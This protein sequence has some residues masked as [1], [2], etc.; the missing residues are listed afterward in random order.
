MKRLHYQLVVIFHLSVIIIPSSPAQIKH[1]MHVIGMFSSCLN[2]TNNSRTTFNLEAETLEKIYFEHFTTNMISELNLT[3]Y[4]DL[5]TQIEIEQLP[6]PV[7]YHSFDVCQNL[8]LLLR[9]IEIITLDLKYAVVKE[10]TGRIETNVL[11]VFTYLPNRMISLLQAVMGGVPFFNIDFEEREDGSLYSADTELY[12]NYLVKIANYL[13]WND[14]FL[15]SIKDNQDSEFPY[16]FYFRRSIDA[17]RSIQNCVHY[18]T[19]AST[20]VSNTSSANISSWLTMNTKNSAVIIFGKEKVTME[21]VERLVPLHHKY[22]TPFASHDIEYFNGNNNISFINIDD[23]KRGIDARTNVPHQ[24][25]S[26][27]TLANLPKDYLQLGLVSNLGLFSRCFVK[28]FLHFPYSSP[29]S[30]FRRF[31]KIYGSR[32]RESKWVQYISFDK[33]QKDLDFKKDRY[34]LHPDISN[35]S[36]PELVC[37]PGFER[38]YGDVSNGFSWKCVECP[39]NHM[40]PNH[41]DT[42][43]L[44]CIGQLNIDN[45]V[46]TRCVDPYKNVF[47]QPLKIELVVLL[48]VSSLGIILTSF[49]VVVFIVKRRTPIVAISDFGLSTIHMLVMCLLFIVIPVPFLLDSKVEYCIW[50]SINISIFSTINVGIMFV[51]SQKL[52]Q[53]FL[54]NIRVR[55]KDVHRTTAWQVFLVLIFVLFANTTLFVGF[56]QQPPEVLAILDEDSKQRT[57][58]CNTFIHGNLVVAS[59]LIVQLL[60]SIQAV[61]GRNLPA[62]MNDAMLLTYATFTG[63]VVFGITFPIVYFQEATKKELTQSLAVVLNTC[64][65]CLLVYA[66]KAIR[67]LLYADKNTT[68]YF[69]TK[70]LNMV[71]QCISVP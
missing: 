31:H 29:I 28:A 59:V 60:C 39:V 57:H 58:Y 70:R 67:M 32:I 7:I 66:Q 1:P 21:M 33:K 68:Q 12:T 8:E 43:C 37:P 51:K 6:F 11:S 69:R 14:V 22:Q 41:G 53:A 42:P 40:K 49:S 4:T 54:S 65:A 2:V 17:F 25:S 36:C 61:R 15:L 62:F 45:G 38:V 71:T 24:F 55:E 63:T 10:G 5:Y 48:S 20:D 13:N 46:R 26:K 27:E 50:K 64:V 3:S 16:G 35:T 52:L 30:V 18:G 34:L 47:R 23:L 9:A 44:P 19:I 56:H